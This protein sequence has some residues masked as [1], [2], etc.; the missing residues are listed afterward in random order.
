MV[1]SSP[2]SSACLSRPSKDWPQLPSLAP[3][4]LSNQSSH[5]PHSWALS[6]PHPLP[7]RGS[8]SQECSPLTSLNHAQPARLSSA[9]G[10]LLQ[11]AFLFSE[12]LLPFV[13]G[14][15]SLTLNCSLIFSVCAYLVFLLGLAAF[16]RGRFS[17]TSGASRREAGAQEM[18]FEWKQEGLSGQKYKG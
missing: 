11:E 17:C 10:H 9:Q 6:P 18:A 2:N 8:S 15:P 1:E 7:S 5:C 13:T 12:L 14:T 4:Q 3:W 16:E